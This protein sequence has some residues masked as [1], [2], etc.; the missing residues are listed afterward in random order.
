MKQH[1]GVGVQYFCGCPYLDIHLANHDFFARRAHVVTAYIEV[2]LL[3]HVTVDDLDAL[4]DGRHR[5]C[6]T[7]G[8][9]QQ[10]RCGTGGKDSPLI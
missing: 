10:D 7:R 4:R 8:G 3:R 1:Q 6:L 9:G 2:A 5:L